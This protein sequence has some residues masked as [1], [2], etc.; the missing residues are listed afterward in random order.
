MKSTV[1]RNTASYELKFLRRVLGEAVSR[2]YFLNNPATGLRVRLE[3]RKEKRPWTAE[4]L[5]TVDADLKAR[6]RFGWLRVT[7]LLGRYQVARLGSSALPLT[8]IDLAAH[9]PREVMKNAK[10]LTQPIDAR[11]L[12]ELAELV[13]HRRAGG[14]A[15]LCDLPKMPSLRMASPP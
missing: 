9:W 2:V 12:P 14:Y 6:E 4:E 15:T 3:P 13:E 7:F 5:A 11:L 8:S 1:G 10:P